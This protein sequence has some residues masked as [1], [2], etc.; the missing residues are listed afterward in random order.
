MVTDTEQTGHRWTVG[1]VITQDEI[2]EQLSHLLTGEEPDG[3]LML[4]LHLHLSSLARLLFQEAA[5]RGCLLGTKKNKKKPFTS[6]NPDP[7]FFL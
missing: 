1:R 2:N 4:D 5:G 6:M 3:H 7:I